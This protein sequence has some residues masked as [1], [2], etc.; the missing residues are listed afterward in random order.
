MAVR[1][2]GWIVCPILA[3]VLAATLPAQQRDSADDLPIPESPS[4]LPMEATW[5][6]IPGTQGAR[7]D[8]AGP[9]FKSRWGNIIIRGKR[10]GNEIVTALNQIRCGRPNV[11]ATY[12]TML[13]RPTAG[14]CEG[15]VALPPGETR[16]ISGD[17][18]NRYGTSEGW[19]VVEFVQRIPDVTTFLSGLPPA[20]T[21][22]RGIWGLTHFGAVFHAE[23]GQIVFLAPGETADLGHDVT[24]VVKPVMDEQ[25]LQAYVVTAGLRGFDDLKLSGSKGASRRAP[26]WFRVLFFGAP[27]LVLGGI[28]YAIRSWLRRRRPS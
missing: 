23:R 14:L 10:N 3:G 15:I 6:R 28:A 4:R 18:Y 20:P 17:G 13:G 24:F 26:V 22:E 9:M 7:F 2:T 27:L 8:E 12:L 16:S 21:A 25:E 5:D 19:T 11:N 1:A